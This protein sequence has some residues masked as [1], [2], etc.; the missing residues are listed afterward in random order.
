M[1]LINDDKS[2]EEWPWIEDDIKAKWQEMELGKGA[3][4]VEH[5]AGW[6]GL[7]PWLWGRKWCLK[8][9]V[10]WESLFLEPTLLLQ[11]DE[12]SFCMPV[13]ASAAGRVWDRGGEPQQQ[14]N[15]E[16]EDTHPKRGIKRWATKQGRKRW[17][18]SPYKCGC[19]LRAVK[20]RLNPRTIESITTQSQRSSFQV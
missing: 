14:A 18:L 17:K 13:S 6:I 11:R 10:G 7:L 5:A 2:D 19:W 12:Q 20:E 15:K 16:T 3:A 9:E 1:D 4:S 8:G